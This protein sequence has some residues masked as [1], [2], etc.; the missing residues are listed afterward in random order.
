MVD[1]EQPA[2]TPNETGGQDV[3]Y[4]TA[5]TGVKVRIS[6]REGLSNRTGEVVVEDAGALEEYT[7]VMMSDTELEAGDIVV[8]GNRRMKIVRVYASYGFANV[9]HYSYTLLET[10]L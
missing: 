10:R 8:W 1:I 3:V 6:V 9:D 5:L 7:R 4:D 2:Y